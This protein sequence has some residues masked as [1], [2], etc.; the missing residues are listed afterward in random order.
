MIGF[1][2]AECWIFY[3]GRYSAI[4]CQLNAPLRGWASM[5]QTL[6]FTVWSSSASDWDECLWMDMFIC[7]IC[8]FHYMF[9]C[10][11]Y[12][13]QPT[14]FMN[15][16]NALIDAVNIYFNLTIDI[17]DSKV[18][19]HLITHGLFL[20]IADCEA[21]YFVNSN[22]FNIVSKYLSSTCRFRNIP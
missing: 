20:P 1:L 10:A 12:S 22:I 3:L 2:I 7:A 4:P 13:A 18:L 14:V 11:S 15:D 8:C 21:N 6:L 17:M 5:L 16:M 9:K 19:I